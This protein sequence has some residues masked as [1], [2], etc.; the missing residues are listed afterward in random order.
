MRIST[1][2]ASQGDCLEKY[3]MLPLLVKK[4][5][6]RK[7]NFAAQVHCI[8]LWAIAQPDDMNVLFPRVLLCLTTATPPQRSPS[9]E[10]LVNALTTGWPNGP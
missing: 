2:L 8:A 3:S 1:P 5:L 4:K 9:V 10:A 7:K 6:Q